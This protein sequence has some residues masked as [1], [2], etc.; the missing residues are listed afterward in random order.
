[1]YGA[2]LERWN[3]VMDWP[4][5]AAALIYMGGYAAQI[6]GP[7]TEPFQSII[8]VV[9]WIVWGIFVV[10]YVV[11]LV[12]A[13][14][15]VRWF[16]RHLLD[17]LIVALPMFRPLRLMRFLTAVTIIE[18]NAGT[19]LR[20]RVAIYTVGATILTVFMASLAVLDAE[21]GQPGANIESF[22][23]A[24]WWSFTTITTVGYGDVYPVTI[25]GRIVAVALMIGG[26]G[27]VGVVT[28]T[29]SSWIVER[30]VSD[31]GQVDA[32]AAGAVGA[33][34][35][36]QAELLETNAEQRTGR[37]GPRSTA[38]DTPAPSQP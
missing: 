6:L 32:A 26:I 12:V 24:I 38:H 25:T 33:M 2:R 10:E 36:A 13:E 23:D 11:C 34:A 19:A 8:G 28:A 5:I 4:M 3:R 31:R 20:G 22:G 37:V 21:K 27:L 7:Q 9:L 17:L 15:R 16:W 14:H 29:L 18:K 1:M 30:V 35:A